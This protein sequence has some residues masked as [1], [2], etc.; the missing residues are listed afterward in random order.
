[1]NR[2][3]SRLPLHI[4]LTM[5]GLVPFVFLLYLALR[6]HQQNREKLDI[7]DNYIEKLNESVD[8]INL[9]DAI[10]MERRYS[11]QKVMRSEGKI[12]LVSRRKKTDSIIRELA[13]Y[14]D[15]HPEFS[16]YTFLGDL[17]GI[18]RSIDRDSISPSTV[19]DY[20]TNVLFRFN[21]LNQLPA[22]SEVYLG[23]VYQDLVS[24]KILSE[25]I[26]YLGIIS[27]NIHNALVT[28]QYMVEILVGTRGVY[29]F[30]KS[31]ETELLLKGSADARKAY[32]AQRSSALHTSV[33]E[34]IDRLFRSYTFDTTYDHERWVTESFLMIDNLRDQQ[35]SVLERSLGKIQIIYDTQERSNL[36]TLTV[37]IALLVIVVVMII[38]ILRNISK[39]LNELEYAA[40]K[41]ARGDENVDIGYYSKD[42]IGSL[43]LSISDLERKVTLRTR[44]LELVN[45]ELESFSY[46]VSHDLRAPLRAII[47]YSAMLEEDHGP[48]LNEEGKR[49]ISVIRAN[50]QRM[51]QLI[52]DL[53]LFSRMGR[54][55]LLK[56]EFDTEKLVREIIDEIPGNDRVQWI[57]GD[58]P[59]TFG[60]LITLRQVWVNLLSN[61]VK[62]SARVEAPVI[63]IGAEKKDDHITYFVKDNGAGF[64]EKYRD[65]LFK[66]FQRLHHQKDFEGTGIG[67]AIVEKIVSKHNGRVWA[68]SGQERGASFYFSLP[69]N[70]NSAHEPQ[71]N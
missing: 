52:D 30:Y 49:L 40:G 66:V 60:D 36:V 56:T 19:I 3:L 50:T 51:G 1:L 5:V 65:K 61:A 21:M 32:Q 69:V 15:L 33:N 27:A 12:D 71:Q 35:H 48:S 38:Y 20:Y 4:K 57:I 55:E 16:R 17:S 62:F 63:Q 47:G 70:K 7:L 46:S 42:A 6:V 31:F 13:V 54:Q 28:K 8:I 37:L 59:I 14:R 2:F 67:L 22:A 25:M 58:L 39:M 18:R 24:Q 45:R 68:T 10:R 34:Y 43:A 41:I 11:F 29:Q 64:D 23:T 26:T 9:I 44:Q 53:L